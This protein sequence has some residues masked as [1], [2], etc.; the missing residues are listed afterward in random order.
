MQSLW[1]F[2]RITRAGQDVGLPSARFVRRCKFLDRANNEMDGANRRRQAG[3]GTAS[4]S[5]SAATAAGSRASNRRMIWINSETS[6]S[7]SMSSF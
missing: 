4:A 2:L 5:A 1:F 6:V 7:R 3:L